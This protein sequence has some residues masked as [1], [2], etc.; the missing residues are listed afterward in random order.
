MRDERDGG[1]RGISRRALLAIM[2]AAAALIALDA[3]GVE[4]RSLEVTE[5]DIPVEALPATLEGY[6]VAQ[7][8]DVHLASVGQ[9]HRAAAAAIDARGCQ[10]VAL[11][12]DILDS[13]AHL[14]AVTE[15]CGLLA[16]PGRTLLATLGNWEHRSR[17]PLRSLAA[18]YAR[19]GARLLGNESVALADGPDVA[20]TDDSSSGRDDVRAALRGLRS[21]RPALLLTH[22][23]GLLDRLPAGAP[24]LALSLSGHTH[25]GQIRVAGR[26]LYLPPDSGRF[27]DGRYDTRHGPAY[28]S[29]GVGTSLVPIRLDCRPELPILRLVRA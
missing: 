17:I 9:L 28:V 23:P 7:L 13:A 16:A 11:T 27:V 8:T 21:G 29:R 12:G 26:A 2:P 5:H 15:L 4:P 25:G 20:A 18:A 1:G 22:A 10:L 6:R 19:G 24:R 3:V 14:P